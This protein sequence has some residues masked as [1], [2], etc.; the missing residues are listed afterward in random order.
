MS[1][2][3]EARARRCVCC[4]CPALLIIS[5]KVALRLLLR[6]TAPPQLAGLAVG[7]GDYSPVQNKNRRILVP[8]AGPAGPA[9]GLGRR[10][11]TRV[12]SPCIL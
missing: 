9:M 11:K 3:E 12:Y 7:R 5:Q 8:Y 6:C 1:Q 4:G 10:E 2:P